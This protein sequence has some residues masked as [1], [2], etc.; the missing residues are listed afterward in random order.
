MTATSPPAAP[1]VVATT[2]WALLL[3]VA[4]NSG[5]SALTSSVMN[6]A[7]PDIARDFRIDPS[8]ASWF[9]LSFLM[10]VTALLLPA[11]RLGDLAGHGRLYLAGSVVFAFGAL[12]CGLAP[13]PAL[14]ILGRIAQGFG[15]AMVMAT[16]PAL[17]TQSVAPGRRGFA[18]GFMSTALYFGLT[19]GPP[20]GGLMVHH[21][22][23]R[24]IFFLTFVSTLALVIPGWR[25]IRHPQA[26]SQRPRFDWLGSFLITAGT[27]SFLLVCTRGL[28]WGLTHPATLV[29]SVAA[30]VLLPVFVRL[31]LSLPAPTVD[32][33]LFRSRTFSSAALGA[34][35]NYVSLFIVLFVLPFALRDGQK[36]SVHVLG[37]L[38]ASQA[39]GMALLA[40][41]SGW[42]SDRLG[43]RGLATGGMIVTAAGL[44]GLA[45]HWPTSGV[46]AP[47]GWLFLVG[48]GTGVFIS[49]N[50]SALMGAAPP[51]RQ[52]I[53][54]GVMALARTLGM[55]FGVAIASALFSTVFEHGKAVTVWSAAADHVVQIGLFFSAATSL[56]VA[57]VSFAGPAPSLQAQQRG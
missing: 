1:Q 45:W 53:A 39:A 19:V 37:R 21:L 3:L 14:L 40:W 18:L 10:T 38:M 12:G 7:L 57:V 8:S 4:A 33:R 55:S 23:W 52:G 41:G 35:L 11:G 17:L 6:V 24:S 27:L 15:S 44:A 47:A 51:D 46:I 43:S 20:L 31:Q 29:L 2:A 49:P 48:A 42:L 50:S 28:T 30:V 5:L 32:M 54:G 9:V 34:M 22:G 16:S 56:L 26:A 13:S 25:I 36:M